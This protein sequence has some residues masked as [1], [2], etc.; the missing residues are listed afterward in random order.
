MSDVKTPVA[1]ETPEPPRSEWVAH[2]LAPVKSV[3][4]HASLFEQIHERP[5][6]R[7]KQD[8]NTVAIW[9]EPES[10]GT[11]DACHARAFGLSGA[12]DVQYIDCHLSFPVLRFD[13]ASPQEVLQLEDII[14]ASQA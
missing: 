3:R 1:E 5:G 8:V 6:P 14:P 10:K 12:K 11:D 2:P 9:I 7:Q 13:R 4:R